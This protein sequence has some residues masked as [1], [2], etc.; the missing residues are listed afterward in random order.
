MVHQ[1]H[2]IGVYDGIEQL[3]VEGIRKDYLKISYKDG[4]TLYIPTTSMDLIQK[5]IGQEGRNPRIN[6]LGGT[7]WV[8]SKG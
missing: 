8:K 7:E 5:Y 4:G 1:S 2:G 3:K 6:K